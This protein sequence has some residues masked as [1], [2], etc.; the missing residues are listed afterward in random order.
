MRLTLIVKAFKIK[1]SANLNTNLSAISGVWPTKPLNP[2]ATAI[3]H[4]KQIK[5]LCL[6]SLKNFEADQIPLPV[7]VE[8]ALYSRTIW[9]FIPYDL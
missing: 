5:F 7:L 1:V 8:T 2:Y 3:S 9:H 4:P 6:A